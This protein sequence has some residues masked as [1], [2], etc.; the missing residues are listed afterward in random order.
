MCIAV[1]WQVR[2]VTGMY[3]CG[4]VVPSESE[5]RLNRQS[6]FPMSTLEFT[7]F[8][9][10]TTISA[11]TSTLLTSTVASET[12]TS[13]STF[14]SQTTTTQFSTTTQDASSTFYTSDLPTSTPG[15]FIVQQQPQT[16]PIAYVALPILACIFVLVSCVAFCA[17]KRRSR[18]KISDKHLSC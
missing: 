6:H 17:I 12:F 15:D 10:E 16:I 18:I 4:S 3:H 2:K 1:E 7:I 5:T 11:V 14:V 9:S 13:E 8:I